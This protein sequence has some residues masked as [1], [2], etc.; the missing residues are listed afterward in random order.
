MSNFYS[1]LHA[2]AF[3]KSGLVEQ[4][5]LNV[6]GIYTKKWN[7][8][9]D[10]NIATAGSC[11]AQHIARNLRKNGYR[12]MDVEPAPVGLPLEHHQS[13]GYSMYSARYGNIY[14]TRQL[15]QL[16]A[17]AFSD[18]PV[19]PIIWERNGLY[20][21]AARPN[22]EPR[23]FSSIEELLDAR[24]YHLEKV[25]ELFTNLDI[26]IFTLGLTET[27]M[28]KATRKVV[29]MAPGV[30]AGDD[31]VDEY[32][33]LNLTYPDIVSDMNSVIRRISRVRKKQNPARYILT[34][35][36]VPLT[37]TATGKH[38]LPA[39]TYSKSVLRAAA[40][41]LSS[42]YRRVD[43]FPSYEIITNPAARGTFFAANMRSVMDEGVEVVMKTFFKAHPPAKKRRGN[44]GS[45]NQSV[46]D[47]QCEDAML[48]AFGK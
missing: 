40:G 42:T 6:D 3:W 1:N 8:R 38:V 29:P 23:G 12:V 2:R 13:H 28:H 43:Y 5:P 36:P 35:S 4:S 41:H 16:L 46:E 48:E 14:T 21:D 10:Q 18:G 17:E 15:D 45:V 11:F 26:F 9:P 39:T 44:V 30:I 7:I 31:V 32:A 20:F 24:E 27:W 33:P 47:V 22:I 25:R 19:K 34:V 37:A